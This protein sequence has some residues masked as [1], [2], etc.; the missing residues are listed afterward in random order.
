[1]CEIVCILGTVLNEKENQMKTAIIDVIGIIALGVLFA[2][3]FIY[4][5]F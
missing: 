2:A 4:G 1:M 3:M 5:G